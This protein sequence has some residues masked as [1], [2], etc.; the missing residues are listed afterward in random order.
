MP[1]RSL[2][3][4][5]EDK[6]VAWVQVF[7]SMLEYNEGKKLVYFLFIKLIKT[8]YQFKEI[9]ITFS[10]VKGRKEYILDKMWICI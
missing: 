6:A 10:Q 9:W 7:T 3:A 4:C 2:D 5:Y 1:K 8:T